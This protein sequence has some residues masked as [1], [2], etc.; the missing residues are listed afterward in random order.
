MRAASIDSTVNASN[1]V[2]QQIVDNA[3]VADLYFRGNE[4][5]ETL[6]DV[7]RVR[8]R[9]L[10]Q[11]ILWTSWN[12]YSQSKLTTA[13]TFEAQKPFLKRVLSSPGGRWLWQNFEDEFEIGFRNEVRQIIASDRGGR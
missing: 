3:G 9:V 12:A 8:Y 2:R 7:E 6:T 5:P 11:S 13:S 1:F 10:L 4:N